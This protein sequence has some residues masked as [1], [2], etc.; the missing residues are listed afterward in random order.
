MF[1]F[2]VS[3]M[4]IE[5]LALETVSCSPSPLFA[6]F[7][8]TPRLPLILSCIHS[9]HSIHL[10]SGRQHIYAGDRKVNQIISGLSLKFK[11]LKH[12]LKIK[13]YKMSIIK[14]NM[15]IPSFPLPFLNTNLFKKAFL[16]NIRPE[17]CANHP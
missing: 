10:L 15:P 4:Y 9:T 3:Y 14:T 8:A 2:Q 7:P 12:V 1:I 13:W 5:F 11:F 16:N 17:K 6:E